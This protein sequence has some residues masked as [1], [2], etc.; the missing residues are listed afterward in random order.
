MLLSAA[1]LEKSLK[2]INFR[3]RLNKM[4]EKPG[5]SQ[6]EFVP[7]K[8]K[9]HYKV[10]EHK[11]QGR[12]VVTFERELNKSHKHIVFFHGGGYIFEMTTMHWKLVTALADRTQARIS[13]VDYP[14]APESSYRETF[15]MVTQSYETLVTTYP[16][17]DFILLGDSA[18]GGL[19]LAFTQKLIRDE[20]KPLP[21]KN[22]LLS[23]WIDIT[24]SNQAIRNYQQLD[25]ILNDDFLNHCANSYAGG[26]DQK[27][28]MLSPIYGE[29]DHMPE[30]AVFYGTH[31]MLLPDCLK[32]KD[33]AE[34]AN[35]NFIFHAY[36][37]M[38][39]DWGILPIPEREQ[40][41]DDICRFLI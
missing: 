12:A 17:D 40:L 11:A 19:A 33:K 15:T 27:Q 30:T 23:P 38:P 16:G 35:A 20:F 14:L 2:F 22:I 9:D 37:N 39:H 25:C 26:D 36:E 21:V 4:M 32:L 24:L 31:E 7:K 8:V 5:R 41:I 29:L 18:G 10:S 28:Y 13:V 1:L 3:Q 6:K 34:S